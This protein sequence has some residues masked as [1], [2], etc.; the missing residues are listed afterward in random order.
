MKA[1]KQEK[2]KGYSVV[3]SRSRELAKMPDEDVRRIMPFYHDKLDLRV[4]GAAWNIAN[5]R[6]E[7]TKAVILAR[8]IKQVKKGLGLL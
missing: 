3:L 2:P 6:G 7:K 1:K 8:R 5:S 4:L